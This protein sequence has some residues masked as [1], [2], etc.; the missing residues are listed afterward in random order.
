MKCDIHIS[1]MRDMRTVSINGMLCQ[2]PHLS[3]ERSAVR[4]WG[5]ESKMMW[6]NDIMVKAELRRRMIVKA[7]ERHI[8]RRA[9]AWR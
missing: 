5:R 6:P 9:D 2:S 1:D 3:A 4:V 8:K 7:R